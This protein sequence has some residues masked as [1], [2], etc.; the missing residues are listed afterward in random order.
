MKKRLKHLL[1]LVMAF[2][3]FMESGVCANA[4]QISDLKKKNQQD[5]DKLDELGDQIDELAGEQQGIKGEM[6]SL[7]AEIADIMASISLIEE[8]IQKKKEQIAQSEKDL[9]AAREDEQNQY[10]A[11][12]VRI[13]FMYEK[14]DMNY[15]NLLMEGGSME[16]LVNK[17]DYIEKIYD[18]DRQLLIR[19]QETRQKI[20]DLKAQL[21]DEESELEMTQDE[22]K[23]EQ[24]GM[25]AAM[26]ELKA[27]SDDYA[28]QISKA[29]QQAE[30]YKTQIKQQN[31][32]IAKLEE[33]ARK[34]AEEEARR[35]AAQNKNNTSTTTTSKPRGTAT[36]NSAEILAANG[37]DI[38]KQIAIYACGFVG[39]PYVPGGTS[40]TNG[41]DCSGFTQS[42]F[43]AYGYSIPR[44]SYSQRTAG[45]EVSFAEA[46]PGDIICYAGHVALYIGNGKIVHAS[47]VKTGIKIG[48]ATYREILSVRRIV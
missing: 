24:E 15:I 11:M 8:D 2:T 34:K 23:G 4:D 17:A 40:L 19:Y 28:L 45:K 46:Q 29:K 38:G 43:K 37:S 16:D 32:Q 31:A 35:K 18:Y 7:Q 13:R 10:N 9:E 27:V 3:V 44:S 1:C 26:A 5:H 33:E 6:D 22:Y 21:E 20:E 41:A 47:G 36:V 42:V 30:V 48:Y 39:N 25:E 12:I 14:G